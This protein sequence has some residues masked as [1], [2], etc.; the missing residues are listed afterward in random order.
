MADTTRAALRWL[1]AKE[2][3]LIYWD[4]SSETFQPTDFGKAVLA[5]GLP[6]ETCLVLKVSRQGD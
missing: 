5:S 1:C 3:A 4:Q 2:Q 6:P